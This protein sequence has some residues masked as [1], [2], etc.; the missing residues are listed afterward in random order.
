MFI[1]EKKLLIEL[2]I[3]TLCQVLILYPNDRSSTE[4]NRHKIKLLAYVFAKKFELYI[5]EKYFQK[6]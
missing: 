1:C 4:I 3:Y 5:L 2:R 6:V